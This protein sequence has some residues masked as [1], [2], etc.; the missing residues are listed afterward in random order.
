VHK[1]IVVHNDSETL[2]TALV[3]VLYKES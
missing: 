1:F 3:L 2:M